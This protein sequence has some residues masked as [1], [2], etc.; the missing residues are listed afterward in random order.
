M[1]FENLKEWNVWWSK[2]DIGELSGINRDKTEEIIR[3]LTTRHIK[4]LAGI[5]RSGKSTILYQI[6]ESLIKKGINPE[7][8]LFIN[9]EDEALLEA[10]FD[11]LIESY[12]ENVAP[13]GDIYLFIDEIQNREK[14][15]FWIKTQYDLKKFKQILISGSSSSLLL[16]KYASL[17]TGRQ[18]SFLINPLSFREFLRFKQFDYNIKFITKE[19]QAKIKA[20][21][22]EYLKYGG[23]P[24]VVLEK[25]K[26]RILVEYYNSIIEKDIITKYDLEEKKVKDLSRYVLSNISSLHSYKKL[27]SIVSLSPTTIIS[28]LNHIEG[29]FLIAQIPIFS[30]K[31]KNH[32]QYPRKI[33]CADTGLAN[34]IAFQFS[35]NLGKLYEN[36]VF[37]DLRREDKEVYYWKS[38]QREE[39]DFII[40]EGLKVKEL[41]QVCYDIK[42]DGVKKREIKALS[43][44]IDEFKLKKGIVITEDYEKEERIGNKLIKFIPLWKWLLT[45]K[46]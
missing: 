38:K 39:V 2:K 34:I 11:K 25:E 15:E 9:M 23:F 3:L 10:D 40:K 44:A 22:K 16:S 20:L 46:R 6:I 36:V 28:Y 8:I 41:I 29:A 13:K 33:Y 27:A 4:I 18:L 17:L 19:Q 31:V 14:W 30:Y 21:L 24:E 5:R 32:L 37:L 45:S 7:N 43:K 35:L 1:V 26:H 42:D 12:L